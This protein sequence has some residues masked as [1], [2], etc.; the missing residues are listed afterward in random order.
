MANLLSTFPDEVENMERCRRVIDLF[1]VSVLLDAGAGPQWS[2]KSSENGRIYRRSEGLALASLEMYKTVGVQMWL[3]RALTDR[4]Q[5][6]F[7]SDKHNKFQVDKAALRQLTVEQ[8]AQGLQSRPGN[9]IAG[10]EGRAQ[11]LV[12]LGEALDERKELWG[13]DGRPGNMLGKLLRIFLEALHVA[14]SSARLP[15]LASLDASIEHCDRPSSSTVGRS[16]KRSYAN[17]A[18]ITHGH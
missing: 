3:R 11:L 4:E 6:L 1:V 7:S 17:L 14:N 9:Q 13:E 2:F 8:L 10:L 18:R 16:H 15:P 5:G 12:R